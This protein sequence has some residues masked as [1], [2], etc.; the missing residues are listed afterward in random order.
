MPEVRYL[1]ADDVLAIADEFLTAL[2]YAQPIL[3]AGGRD[4]LESAVHGARV[5]A[6]YGGVNLAPQAAA[7][8][9]GI[10]Q[11]QPFVDGNKRA[12]FAAC[13]VFLRANGHPLVEDAHD[14]LA[15]EV[16]GLSSP[17]SGSTAQEDLASWLRDHVNP[18]ITR[19]A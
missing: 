16:I 4:L 15:E 12:A 14:D 18:A 6:F 17:H 11:N 9:H 2:G 13:E 7:L 3:R 1:T 5:F 19:A 10:A 8:V